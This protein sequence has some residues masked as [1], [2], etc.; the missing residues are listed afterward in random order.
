MVQI[1]KIPW[2]AWYGDEDLSLEFPD[3]WDVGLFNMKDANEISKKKIENAINNPIGTPPLEEIARGKQNAVIVVEDISRPTSMETILNIILTKLN[4]VGIE[5]DKITLI[6]ALGSHRPLDRRD[7]IKKVGLNIVNR[8]NIE[9]HHPYEN[10]IYMGESQMGTPIYLNKTYHDSDLKIAVGSVVP[11]PLAG[12]GGGAKIIL[13]GIS[14]IETLYANHVAGVKGSSGGIGFV[15]ELRKDIEYVCK[16]VGLDFSVNIV[17]TMRRGIAGVFV[18]HFINAHRKAMELAKEVYSTEIP[19]NLN[20]DIGFFNL[21]PEDTELFQAIKGFNFIF[22]SKNFLKRN[23][24]IIFLTAASEGRGFHSLQGETGAKLYQNWGDSIIFKG[25]LKRKNFGI[26]SPNINRAD[27]LHIYPE[28][29]IF[30]K[31]FKEMVSALEVIYGKAPK[32]GIFPCSIQ[33]SK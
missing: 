18:G 32:V 5:D 3:S 9:N 27:V 20:L 30:R 33:L 15:T 7:S 23:C 21:Y 17:S 13:P 1:F 24:A 11:H 31:D 26:F 19:S 22:S 25:F 4:S 28:K 12:Y 10:L 14:G 2:A 16:K 8:I 6:Y 29:T